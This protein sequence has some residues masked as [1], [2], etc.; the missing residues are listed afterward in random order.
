MNYCLSFVG[1]GQRGLIPA[2]VLAQLEKETGKLTR[3]LVQYV[4]GTSTGAL[5]AG[6]VAAGIP[7]SVMVELYTQRTKEVFVPAGI[8]SD[9]EMVARGHKYDLSNLMKLLR[10]VFGVATTWAMNDCPIG[11]MLAACAANG[12]DWFFV[13]DGAHNAKTTGTVKLLE[14]MCASAAAP[15]YFD[16]QRVALPGIGKSLWMF[17]GGTGCVANPSYQAAVEMFWY[18]TYFPFHPNNPTDMSVDMRM[19]TLGTGY[20]PVASDA[21]I[22]PPSGLL[23]GIEFA[24]DTLVDTSEDWVDQ[25]VYRQWPRMATK[26]DWALPTAIAMDD[27][28]AIPELTKIGQA[29]AAA[30][31]WKELLAL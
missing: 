11:I 18:D 29:A 1:G 14:A 2:M 17:D 16:P 12:H 22:A 27:L 6:A 15:T 23:A 7:A 4:A 19:I 20:Y 28:S 25:A 5:L 13:R 3:E 9:A 26:I 31:N 30:I 21:D 10:S 24:T 8:L